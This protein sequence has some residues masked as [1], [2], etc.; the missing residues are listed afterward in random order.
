[1]STLGGSPARVTRSVTL[2][3]VHDV[4]GPRVT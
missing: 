2:I 1:V 4:G 3:I